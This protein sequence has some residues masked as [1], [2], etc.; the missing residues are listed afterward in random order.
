MPSDRQAIHYPRH[1]QLSTALTVDPLGT[2]HFGDD[3]L[4]NE[5]PDAD[6]PDTDHFATNFS[7]TSRALVRRI[8]RGR[9][10]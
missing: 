4:D 2:E 3:H 9:S 10:L 8:T 1:S 7:Y 5:H 6:N